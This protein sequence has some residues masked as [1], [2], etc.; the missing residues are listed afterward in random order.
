MNKRQSR[1]RGVLGTTAQTV[2]REGDGITTIA[3]ERYPERRLARLR[4]RSSDDYDL[5]WRDE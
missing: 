1:L 4:G 2:L 3:Y 5:T